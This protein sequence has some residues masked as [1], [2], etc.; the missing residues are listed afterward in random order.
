MDHQAAG[1]AVWRP[2]AWMDGGCER[3]IVWTLG[4]WCRSEGG[5]I[6]AK[7]KERR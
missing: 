5:K 3:E 7:R 6:E 1:K 4:S 2:D